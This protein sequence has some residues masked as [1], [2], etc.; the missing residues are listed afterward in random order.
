MGPAKPDQ[1]G[2]QS[3]T[4]RTE[5]RHAGQKSRAGNPGGSFARNLPVCGHQKFIGNCSIHSLS[6]LSLGATILSCCYVAIL[7]LSPP[8]D[9]VFLFL[10]FPLADARSP[11]SRTFPGWDQPSSSIPY[12]PHQEAPRWGTSKTAASAK[13]VTLATRVALLPGI[14]W[15][16]G[17]KNSSE[18]K[19]AI[20]ELGYS[21]AFVPTMPLY[22]PLQAFLSNTVSDVCL[23]PRLKCNGAISA[24]CNLCLLDSNNPPTS[25]KDFAMLPRLVFD[26]WAEAIQLP[27]PPKVLG[28]QEL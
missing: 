14:S 7:D 3:R 27:W 15:S 13:R 5:K 20:Y 9:E 16:V 2:I 11:Q 4:L 19:L 23:L 28:L 8:S 17:N 1:K 6:A 24:H 22:L 12:T 18:T 26:S 10:S 21:G 25:R